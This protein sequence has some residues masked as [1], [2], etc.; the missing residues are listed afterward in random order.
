LLPQMCI[1]RKDGN[2]PSIV[3][4]KR[5][6]TPGSDSNASIILCTWTDHFWTMHHQKC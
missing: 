5:A 4:F 1:Q 2:N 3:A 6:M